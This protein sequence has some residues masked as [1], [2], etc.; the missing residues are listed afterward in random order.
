MQA[1]KTNFPVLITGESGTGKEV[2]ARII[3]CS[4]HRRGRPFVGVNCAAIPSELLESELFGYEEG[5]FT[6]AKKGGK[7]GKFIQA[8]GGTIFLDEIGDM[9]L[10]M[11]AKILRILQE[12]EVDT[13][14][15]SAPIPVDVRIISATRRNLEQMVEDGTFR[16]DLYYR[17]NVINLHLPPLRSRVEDIP[18]LVQYFIDKLNEEYKLNVEIDKEVIEAFCKYSWHG[19]VRELENVIKGA[20]AVC[21][22]LEIISTDL[23]AKFGIVVTDKA[24]VDKKI[25]FGSSEKNIDALNIVEEVHS[26]GSMKKY[27][28]EKE[29]GIVLSTYERFRSVR[30]A[31]EYLGMSMPTY[32]RKLQFYRD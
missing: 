12:K 8:D 13:I 14:G 9:P 6:G 20:Y 16:E 23:P 3:H 32:A 15:G 2:F 25:S 31:A 26:I 4:G 19:N 28:A 11:Q 30:K 21:D 17:L 24:N 1:A 7:K 22:G 27:L 29:R 18:P 10:L 5:A